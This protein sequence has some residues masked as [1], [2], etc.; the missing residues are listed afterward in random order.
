[1][2]REYKPA[3]SARPVLKAQ[4]TQAGLSKIKKIHKQASGCKLYFSGVGGAWVTEEDDLLG[5]EKRLIESD[6]DPRLPESAQA[7]HKVGQETLQQLTSAA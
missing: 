5:F 7:R 3:L 2:G 4:R 6:A 1:M